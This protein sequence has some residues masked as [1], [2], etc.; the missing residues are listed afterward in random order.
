M[1]FKSERRQK[2]ADKARRQMVVTG[3]STKTVILPTIIKKAQQAQE[4]K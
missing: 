2:Q 3:R 4:G 1:E